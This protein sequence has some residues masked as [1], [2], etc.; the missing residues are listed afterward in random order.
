MTI[1]YP[2]IEVLI[3]DYLVTRLAA[4][5]DPVADD[6]RVGTIKTAPGS[7]Q[8]AKEIVVTA[9]YTSTSE[10]MIRN[11]TATIEVYAAGYATASALGLLTSAIII[12]ITGL[13]IKKAEVTLG[14]VRTTE[15]SPA[16][17]RSISVDFIVKGHSL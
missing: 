10:V 15:D 1:T 6:V 16:E 9:N 14:P 7:T 12:D 8:P 13:H 4:L 2:D 3:V 5:S 17:K 11:A